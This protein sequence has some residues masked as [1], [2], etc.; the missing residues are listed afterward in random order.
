[1][2]NSSSETIVFTSGSF[3]L[4][5]LGHLLILEKSAAL[6]TKLVVG[7]SSDELIEEYKGMKPVIPFEERIRIIA[8]LKCVDKAVKQN[9]L[10]EIAQLQEERADIVTIGDDWIGKHL[11]GLEW[12]KNQPG[13]R[14]VYFPYTP[15]VSTT[16][17]KKAIIRQSHEILEATLA[18]E[19]AD[20]LNWQEHKPTTAT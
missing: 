15:G 4:F 5:H 9:H 19:E 14:V 11:E 10:T 16:S 2:A 8:A 18:R 13:K 20:L 17:I 1:V 12:M 6:G 3:D 7:V